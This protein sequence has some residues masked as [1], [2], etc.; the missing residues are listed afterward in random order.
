MTY[1]SIYDSIINTWCN[2]LNIPVVDAGYNIIIISKVF[3][4]GLYMIVKMIDGLKNNVWVGSMQAAKLLEVGQDKIGR[5]LYQAVKGEYT[6]STVVKTPGD[7]LAG[8]LFTI[9]INGTIYT[10]ETVSTIAA[11]DP[12]TIRALVAGTANK[13]AVSDVLTAK[14]AQTYAENDITVTAITTEPTDTETIE[15]Y[16][17]V[18]V[19]YETLRLGNG[20]ASD[21]IVWVQNVNGLRTAYPYTAPGE[22]GKAVIYCESTD[23]AVLV[24]SAGLIANA[25]ESIKYDLNGKSQPPVEFFEF[26]NT[27]YVKAVRI[28]QIRL[29][30][31]NGVPAE[32]TQIEALVRDYLRIKRPF[33]HT[34]NKFI[35][36]SEG[37]NTFE[38]T[39]ALV[40]IVQLLANAGI[41]FDNITMYVK[42]LSTGVYT[43]FSRYVVGYRGGSTYPETYSPSNDPALAAYYGECPKLELINFV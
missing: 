37:Y 22:A 27:T 16:R 34:V 26:V 41:T 11:G 6:C 31:S 32:Q 18:V 35:K 40:D 7:I 25:I 14:Q 20:N 17:S 5:G 30:I 23:S 4:F 13:L 2:K 12:V 3:A 42:I 19:A 33:L 10:F 29:D 24:P 21:Y 9:E 1:N 39:V 15:H 43:E 28:S 8:T 38:N 36:N